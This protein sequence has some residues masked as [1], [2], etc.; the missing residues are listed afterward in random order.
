MNRK[1]KYVSFDV[2][3]TLVKRIIPE[4]QMYYLI[5]RNLE[6]KEISCSIG[7]AEKRITAEKNLQKSKV[8]NYTIWDIYNNEIFHDLSN[9]E[10]I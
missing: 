9:E 10:K 6:K 8:K 3:D 1:I 5:E 7:F 4:K 2:Y